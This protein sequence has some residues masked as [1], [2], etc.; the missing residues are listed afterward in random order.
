MAIE[1]KDI[2]R[3]LE[4]IS[5]EKLLENDKNAF[6]Q[7]EGEAWESLLESI[8]A[9]GIIQPIIIRKDKTIVDG[10]NRRRAALHFGYEFVPVLTILDKLSPEE[11]QEFVDQLNNFRRHMTYG[12]KKQYVKAKYWDI[13]RVKHSGGKGD[14]KSNF[15]T[16][17]YISKKTGL[18][19]SLVFKIMTD[20]KKDA[21]TEKI[22]SGKVKLKN[23]DFQKGYRLFVKYQKRE[24][25]K[26]NI[27]KELREMKSEIEKIAP[28]K[29]FVRYQKE[30]QK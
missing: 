1:F 13:I 15:N 20:L 3:K 23:E 14:G 30:N 5:P 24:T 26:L 8:E 19:K 12:D 28:L 9:K 29:Y 10:H 25:E 17:E 7:L 6:K 21:E 11:E 4:F 16:A 2:K 18:G 22:A 27:E